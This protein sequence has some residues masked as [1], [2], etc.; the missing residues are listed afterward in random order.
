MP[1][2][3]AIE[4]R[5]YA[6]DPYNGFFPSQGR[7]IRLRLPSGPGVRHD[8]CLFHGYVVADTTTRCWPS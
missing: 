8:G 3:W 7:I 4:C 1:T 2:G 5:I 6:E